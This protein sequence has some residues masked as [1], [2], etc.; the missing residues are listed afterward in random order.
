[1]SYITE[2]V[3]LNEKTKKEIYRRAT[4]PCTLK[5]IARK[6]IRTCLSKKHRVD[7]AV[8]KLDLPRFLQRYLLFENV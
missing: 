6:Q 1:L 5:N 4:T 2:S 3:G 8:D 7:Q